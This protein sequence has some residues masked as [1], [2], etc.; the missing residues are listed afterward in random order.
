[1]SSFLQQ[2]EAEFATELRAKQTQ[3]DLTLA[4]AREL[5]SSLTE[6]RRRLEGLQARA[7][8]R[9]EMRQKTIN[10]RRA[11]AERKAAP[12]GVVNGLASYTNI[13]VGEADKGLDIHKQDLPDPSQPIQLS[14]KQQHY[15]HSL[16]TPHVMKARI[17]AYKENNANCAAKVE[18]LK[19]RS[20]E[21]EQKYKRVIMLCTGV[22]GDKVQDVLTNLVEA[23]RSEEGEA[24]EDGR[25]R[26]F[27]LQVEQGDA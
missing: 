26:H 19:S 2:T 8:K 18:A 22:E 27:L 6:E 25:L 21:L 5:S 11:A 13:S 17:A 15:L 23:V 4:R 20:G 10:L 1:M 24:Y 9:T 14:Q 12:N 16:P 3:T 7:A